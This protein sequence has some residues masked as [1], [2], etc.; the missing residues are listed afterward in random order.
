[1]KLVEAYGLRLERK[2]R[3]LAAR[4][5]GR[6]LRPRRDRTRRIAP[7]AIL[8]AGAVRNEAH[9][10]GPW[11]DH[12]RRLGAGHFLMVDNGSTDGTAE[13]LEAEPDVSLWETGASYARANFG[14]HWINAL[15]RRHACGHWLLV[16]DP[17]EFLVYPFCDSRGLRALADHLAAQGRRSMGALL[18]DLY[19]PGPGLESPCAPGGDP[20]AAAPFF[21]ASAC[22]HRVDPRYRNLWIQGGPR[23][24]AFFADRPGQAPALNKIPLVRWEAGFAFVSSTHALLPRGLNLTYG[25]GEA[26]RLTGVLLHTKFV[27]G[28]AAKVAE[29]QERRQHFAGGREYLAYAAHEGTSL[30]TPASLRYEGWRQLEALGLLS[31][32]DWF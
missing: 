16:A 32:G 26:E 8:V 19:G 25:E 11:L 31:R 18:L 24:R 20:V 22:F 3:L 1:M 10:L 17:D 13:R 23:L 28:L 15:A 27:S 9:R 2:R 30:M 6:D 14:V 21:D 7:G 12:H 29:E 5:H 4:L